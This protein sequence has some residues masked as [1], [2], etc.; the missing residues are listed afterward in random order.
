MPNVDNIVPYQFKKG[1]SGNPKGRPRKFVST[2]IDEL[3][4]KGIKRVS[5]SQVVTLYEK[6][7]NATIEEL[8][9]LS[10]DKNASWEVRQTTKYMLRYPERAWNDIHDRAHG[11]A[12]Q[13]QEVEHSGE[14]KTNDE[15][16]KNIA[17]SLN[18][19]LDDSEGKGD[20]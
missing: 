10:K 20:S 6:L 8:T 11:K 4:K 1:Q 15:E 16:I 5:P 18:K 9:E 17:N 2:V 7:L 12:K 3:E 14:I 13:R 19:L